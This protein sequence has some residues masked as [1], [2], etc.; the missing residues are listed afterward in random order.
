[1]AVKKA[2]RITQSLKRTEC[3]N[4]MC[5]L[6]KVVIED[7]IQNTFPSDI[8]YLQPKKSKVK[9]VVIRTAKSHKKTKKAKKI[10]NKSKKKEN[11]KKNPVDVKFMAN[12]KNQRTED[13]VSRI[14]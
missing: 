8:K 3:K 4:D 6:S 14:L 10:L 7:K 5:D 2:R 13:T 1:M 12:L 11:V 9:R